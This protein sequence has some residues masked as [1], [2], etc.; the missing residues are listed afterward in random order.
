MRPALP[1]SLLLTFLLLPLVASDASAD[2]AVGDYFEYD[3]NTFVDQGTGSYYQYSDSMTSHS[4][5]TIESIDGEWV[6]VRGTGSW[7]FEGS[8]GYYDSGSINIIFNFSTLSRRYQSVTDLDVYYYDPAVWFWIPPYTT[9][10]Q[11]L[12]ILDTS[13]TVT[14]IDHTKWFG[15]IPRKVDVLHGEGSY[16]RDDVYGTF[17]AE[18]EDT[19][20]FDR[21]TGFISS[22]RY[23]EHDW[24][25][26]GSFRYR[27][28]VDVTSSSYVLPV[29]WVTLVT[30]ILGIPGAVVAVALIVWRVR[31]GPSRFMIDT[32]SGPR[33]VVVKRLRDPGD[34]MSVT[35]RASRYF[36]PFLSVIAS[37]ARADRDPVIVAMSG[38][39]LVGLA[40]L[41]R[42]SMLGSMFAVDEKVGKALLRRLKMVDFF[43]E[44]NGSNWD[45]SPAKKMDSFEILELRNPNPAEFDA[46]R[47]RPMTRN[48]LDRVVSISH[49][50]YGGKSAK[51]IRSCFEGGDVAFVAMNGRETVGF[52][53]ATV[54]GD[55]ARL[56]TLTVMAQSRARGLGS[57]LM[58][59]RLTVLSIL[60]VN[61][62][63]VEISKHNSASMR[64]ATKAGFARV[65]ETAYYSR[66]PAK[67]EAVMQRRL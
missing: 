37:R 8:D 51:W 19:Y 30:I 38:H 31:R 22:E 59:A 7:R 28:E 12:R 64:V 53:F 20:T 24:S 41:D 36:A 52:G 40:T 5:Y 27:A 66:R 49:A 32:G 21:R 17:D 62:V 18:F 3:Y 23:V 57:E 50:V 10:G 58:S 25:S 4:R 65:G 42:E 45:L 47:V 33:Q 55:S 48:D 35:P 6:T 11:V 54:A 43:V 26:T 2:P 67:A 16:V 14:D 9:V 13:Y 29:D 44:V 34:I 56:H 15:M 1:A 61:R 63:I 46:S 60:G 39:E